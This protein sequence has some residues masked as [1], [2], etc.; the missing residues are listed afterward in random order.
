MKEVVTFSKADLFF[1]PRQKEIIELIALGC[2]TKEIALS[3][4]ISPKTVEYHRSELFH[5]LGID[6][7]AML[8]HFAIYQEIVPVIRIRV[9]DKKKHGLYYEPKT[10]VNFPQTNGLFKRSSCSPG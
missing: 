3:L 8:V 6:S 1:T 5:Q 4:K 2:N 9:P 7:I 10:P